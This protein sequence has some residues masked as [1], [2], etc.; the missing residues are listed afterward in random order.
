MAKNTSLEEI[1]KLAAQ[2]SDPVREIV[3]ESMM[4]KE[5]RRRVTPSKLNSMSAKQLEQLLKL[6]DTFE[7]LEKS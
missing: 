4:I 1:K 6:L 2:N 3:Y 7:N 5:L